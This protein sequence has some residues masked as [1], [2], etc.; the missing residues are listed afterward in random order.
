MQPVIFVYAARCTQL[1]PLTASS[2]ASHQLAA[3]V[4]TKPQ[5]APLGFAHGVAGGSAKAAFHKLLKHDLCAASRC[6]INSDTQAL[7]P[8]GHG[9]DHGSC[10]GQR[11]YAAS[12]FREVTRDFLD[13]YPGKGPL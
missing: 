4:L 12:L 3:L 7:A 13:F 2:N 1:P 9:H 11:C 6:I 5:S 8:C 10:K